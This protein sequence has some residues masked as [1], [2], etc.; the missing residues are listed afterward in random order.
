M[1]VVQNG[2]AA[3]TCLLVCTSLGAGAGQLPNLSR[4]KFL[5]L[6]GIVG[7][8]C[9]GGALCVDFVDPPEPSRPSR[10]RPVIGLGM[11]AVACVG[12]F[13]ISRRS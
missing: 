2:I 8:V 13:W 5:A 4:M 9:L 11:A 1:S 7:S 6:L 10:A 3:G 12:G